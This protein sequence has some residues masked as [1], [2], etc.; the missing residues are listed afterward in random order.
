MKNSLTRTLVIIFAIIATLA[1][2]C[3]YIIYRPPVN[4]WDHSP[5]A[6][7]I[8]TEPGAMH[9]D[10]SY[11]PDYQIWGNGDI[12]WVEYSETG[13]RNIFTG[14][15][16]E[17]ELESIVEKFINT[18][19]FD[20]SYTRNLEDNSC[21]RMG[22]DNNLHIKLIRDHA[23]EEWLLRSSPQICELDEFLS[24]GG[25]VVGNFFSHNEA[26]YMLFQ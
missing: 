13:Q 16:T 14:K 10:Y 21:A 1:L 17:Q 11:I 9:V 18:R 2:I 6:L 12:I 25:G 22:I 8:Y 5:E 26:G 19:I 24:T 7:V 15:L 23:I 3:I 20:P 4:D